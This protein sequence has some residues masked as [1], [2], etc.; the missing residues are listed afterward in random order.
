M[1][2]QQTDGLCVAVDLMILTIRDGALMLL[3][4]PRSKPPFE[5]SWS[6]PGRIMSPEESAESLIHRLLSQMLPVQN[7]YLEQLYTF[8]SLQRDPRGRTVSIAYMILLPWCCVSEYTDREGLPLRSFRVKL[9]NKVLQL[10]SED[11]TRLTSEDLAFDH[12]EIVTMGVTRLRGKIGYTDVGFHFLRNTASFS[13]GE[14]KTIFQAILDVP[15][16]SSNF[17]RSIRNSYET[18]GIIEPIDYEKPRGRGRPSL[19]Y[20]LVKQS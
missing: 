19:L 10:I 7:P 4:A 11:G 17:R 9:E 18:S 16:D 8:T 5:G 1:Q 15:I 6:L 2:Y 20:R 12:G 3:L 13:L 14:L